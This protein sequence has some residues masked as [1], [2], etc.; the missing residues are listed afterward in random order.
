MSASAN[1]KS[2]TGRLDVFTRVIGDRARGFDQMPAGY[3]GPLYLEV[4]PRTFPVLVRTGSRLSQ[5]RFRCGDTRLSPA[6]H[7]ALHAS[8]TL[9]IGG[10]QPVGEGVALSID[11]LGEGRDGLWVST[12]KSCHGGTSSADEVASIDRVNRARLELWR[13]M[14]GVRPEVSEDALRKSWIKAHAQ[15][16]V[17]GSWIERDDGTWEDKKC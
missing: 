11:L 8:D 5:M 16:V 3:K 15:G 14:H 9:V 10:D 17:C 6:A 1:P 13:W 7:Q 4:S 2:S 12:R